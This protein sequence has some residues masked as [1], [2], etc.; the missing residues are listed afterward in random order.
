[1]RYITRLKQP[2]EKRSNLIPWEVP[3]VMGA[4][5]D[6]VLVRMTQV[7][8]PNATLVLRFGLLFA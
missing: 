7:L 8:A 3:Y 6:L 2:T 4:Q 1:M 5:R